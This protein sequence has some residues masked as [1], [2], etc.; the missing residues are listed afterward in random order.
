MEERVPYMTVSKKQYLLIGLT[1]GFIFAAIF[2]YY[3][4]FDAA[5]NTIVLTFFSSAFVLKA[6]I[7]MAIGY[8]VSCFGLRFLNK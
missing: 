1:W 5:N 8:V 6:L 3:A 2:H 4:N 7:G